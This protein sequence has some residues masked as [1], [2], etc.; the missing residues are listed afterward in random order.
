MRKREARRSR[1]SK[2][3]VAIVHD[4]HF[5]RAMY[6][7]ARHPLHTRDDH[8]TTIVRV[9]EILTTTKTRRTTRVAAPVAAR[10]AGSERNSKFIESYRRRRNSR[11]I[12]A[13]ESGGACVNEFPRF[14]LKTVVCWELAG[15]GQPRRVLTF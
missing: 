7:A 12:E 9:R 3:D 5:V 10:K 1:Y 14:T 2:I 13:I 15:Y 4:A 8:V 11:Y 6:H